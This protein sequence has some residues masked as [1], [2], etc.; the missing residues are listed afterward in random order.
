MDAEK[1]QLSAAQVEPE[2]ERAGEGL[3][4]VCGHGVSG[5]R[6]GGN[7]TQDRTATSQMGQALGCSRAQFISLGMGDPRLCCSDPFSLL[8]LTLC[9]WQ[10]SRLWESLLACS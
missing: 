10:Q 4:C 6:R 5:S 8:P 7:E 9:L 3:A 1:E 2:M